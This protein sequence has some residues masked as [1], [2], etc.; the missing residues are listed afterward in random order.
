MK[1]NFLGEDIK[2]PQE[3]EPSILCPLNRLE[4]RIKSGLE[5][6]SDSYSGRDYWTSY[7]TSWL[8]K[9][10]IPQNK[11]LNISYD[12]NS[13]FFVESKS[14]K[15]YL[16][17]LNNK[18]FTSIESVQS[19]IKKDLDA[20]LKTNVEV[21]LEDRPRDIFDDTRSINE[22]SIAQIDQYPNSL[23]IEP[24]EEE[25]VSEAL[26]CSLFRS[27]CPVTAQPDWA[28]IYISY[29]GNSIQHAGLLRYLLSYRNHQGF[30]EECVERIY[31]DILRRC[32]LDELSV[33]AN[34]LRRGGIEIN[35]V[36]TTS[37][38][39][40]DIYREIRQ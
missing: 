24:G 12:C 23:I 20:A 32:R 37:N 28:T 36:R 16:Y 26:S 34:F 15:L 38:Y 30:H 1:K 8:N 6:F 21:Q 14:L 17:S 2:I 3:Y 25:N 22:V 9:K 11:I 18:E 39:N 13:K 33:R 4:S 19:L 40:V 5:E 27:L 31:I 29:R 10:G 7:E 35:P